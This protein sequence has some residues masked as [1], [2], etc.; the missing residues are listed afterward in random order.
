MAPRSFGRYLDSHVSAGRQH[1]D[2]HGRAVRGTEIRGHPCVR[3]AE[4]MLD[5]KHVGQPRVRPEVR[6]TA[7]DRGKYLDSHCGKYLDSHGIGGVGRRY[8]DTH[9]SGW[10]KTCWTATLA[11]EV[12][13]QPTGWRCWTAIR[14]LDCGDSLDTW[15]PCVIRSGTAGSDCYA[16]VCKRGSLLHCNRSLSY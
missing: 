5:G 6:W 15:M 8:V 14:P 12:P 9:A 2:S 10:R 7:R 4:N 11:R 16:K 3:L 1:L 13:G